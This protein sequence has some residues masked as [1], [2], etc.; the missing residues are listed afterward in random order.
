MFWQK[1]GDRSSPW[2]E[3][4]ADS[5]DDTNLQREEE[6]VEE[7]R[8]LCHVASTAIGHYVYWVPY[9]KDLIGYESGSYRNNAA[10][11]A[12][13]L[14]NERG[15]NDNDDDSKKMGIL[16]RVVSRHKRKH[17]K[18]QK[19]RQMQQQQ[20]QQQQQHHLSEEEIDRK[21]P[22]RH[23]L[24]GASI[25]SHH[26]QTKKATRKRHPHQTRVQSSRNGESHEKEIKIDWSKWK[27]AMSDDFELSTEQTRIVKELA[28]RVLALAK[29]VGNRT[30]LEI[31]RLHRM[32]GFGDD[33]KDN[34]NNNGNNKN[35]KEKE[36][37]TSF[38]ERVER[39]PWGGVHNKDSNRWYPR[40]DG[41]KPDL[42][43]GQVEGGRL[44]AS[45]LKIMK[46]PKVSMCSL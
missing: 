26:K 20:Q 28:R 12:E 10:N 33:D 6:K 24:E 30:S 3:R 31:V 1:S 17:D 13:A 42:I 32:P 18:L 11:R 19:Q 46:Y 45:Y 16:Q 21:H 22:I 5:D 29:Q 27:Y 4:K 35:I 40:K 23:I 43:A 39:V 36:A 41:R 37:G 9:G 8:L 7:T 14:D 2:E 34:S 44:L 25:F 15:I 38:L